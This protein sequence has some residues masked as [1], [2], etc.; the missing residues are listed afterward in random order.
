MNRLLVIIILFLFCFYSNAQVKKVK[1][2]GVYQSQKTE[3]YWYYLKFVNDS[4]VIS[5]SSTGKP[6]EI[7]S[8]FK[9]SFEGI[10]IG[11]YYMKNDSIFFS[12]TSKNGTVKYKGIILRNSMQLYSES[13]INGNTSEKKYKFRKRK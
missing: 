2:N 8:W 5:T 9:N 13:L 11:K 10:S 12:T 4:V 1:T 7:E 6:K 3:D